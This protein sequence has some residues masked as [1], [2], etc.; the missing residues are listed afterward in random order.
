MAWVYIV[1]AG[2]I[3]ATWPF[4][5]K[6][7][8]SNIWAPMII[9]LASGIPM[10]YL[11]SIAMKSVP[12]GT[13]YLVFAAIGGIGVTLASVLFLHESTNILRL[14]SLFLAITG[15]IGL[16]FFGASPS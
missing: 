14:V 3:D 11:L 7:F 6:Q 4:L 13:V 9:S 10:Y 8:S 5:L 16:K 12:V 2:L 1:L 15:I